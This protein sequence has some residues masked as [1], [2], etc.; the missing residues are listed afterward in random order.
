MQKSDPSQAPV[1][2]R[3]ERKR[4]VVMLLWR[5]LALFSLA[6]AVIGVALPIM[7]TVPFLILSAWA[8]SKGWP[9]FEIWLIEHRH[10]GPPIVRWRESGAVPR[11][12]KWFSTLMMAAS[13]VGMQLFGQIPLSLRI[14]VP[15]VMAA[16]AI[17]LW[18]RPER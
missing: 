2:E 5:A 16:V 17:W 9:A 3:V 15:L 10:F 13:A 11:R 8:A 7:P 1:A 4:H 18:R 6:L 14:G 12:A